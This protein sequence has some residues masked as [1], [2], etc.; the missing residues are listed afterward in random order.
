MEFTIEGLRRDGFIGFMA[1]KEFW[2]Q[3]YDGIPDQPG[4]YAI[5]RRSLDP[6]VFL[7]VSIGGHF[8]GK[9]PTVA[10]SILQ[11]RWVSGTEVIYIGKAGGKKLKSTLRKRI[12]EYLKFGQGLPIGHWG[13]R[14]I[15]QLEGSENLLVAYKPLLNDDPETIEKS[16]IKE[17]E[18]VYSKKPYA[19]LRT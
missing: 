12:N 19:N 2:A 16:L 9:N 4:I 10:I 17:F 1:I 3:G 5:L 14:Y 11:Q 6:P 8:K 18:T 13:G 7:S 15:W